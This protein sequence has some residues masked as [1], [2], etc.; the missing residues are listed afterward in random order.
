MDDRQTNEFVAA[1]NKNE[2]TGGD[3]I[4]DVNQ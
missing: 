4:V 2:N 3:F 1:S